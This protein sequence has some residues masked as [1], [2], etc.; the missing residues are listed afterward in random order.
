MYECLF[1]HQFIESQ[2][3]LFLCQYQ[4]YLASKQGIALAWSVKLLEAHGI[5]L[6]DLIATASYISIV[7]E[8]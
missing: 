4:L 8:S 5:S 2:Y 6:M 7:S 3:L 1:M